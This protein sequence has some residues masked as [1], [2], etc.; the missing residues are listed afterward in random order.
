[1]VAGQLTL[2]ASVGGLPDDTAL[3]ADKSVFVGYEWVEVPP[4]EADTG[5]VVAGVGVDAD[6]GG[7]SHCDSHLDKGAGI[8]RQVSLTLADPCCQ[9]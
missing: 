2:F 8:D 3:G 9:T 7:A 1:M 5:I 4:V 6:A